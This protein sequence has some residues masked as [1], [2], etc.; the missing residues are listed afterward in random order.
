MAVELQPFQVHDNDLK[1]CQ[2]KFKYEF[3]YWF[4]LVRNMGFPLWW[5]FCLKSDILKGK[6]C[7][8]WK[9]MSTKIRPHFRKYNVWKFHGFNRPSINNFAQ[10][11]KNLEFMKLNCFLTVL[12]CLLHLR[13]SIWWSRHFL[14][15][16]SL[17]LAHHDCLGVYRVIHGKV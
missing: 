5:H 13:S 8:L 1:N 6:Y 15:D 3:S 10:Y 11:Y 4:V 17:N 12:I 2:Q 9:D 14:Y 7:L 16:F